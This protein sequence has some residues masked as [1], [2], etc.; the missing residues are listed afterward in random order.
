[1]DD[2]TSDRPDLIHFSCSSAGRFPRALTVVRRI[3][4]RHQARRGGQPGAELA[5]DPRVPVAAR[6]ILKRI[7]AYS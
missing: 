3:S 5:G 7:G 2:W 1:M 6:S 4:K